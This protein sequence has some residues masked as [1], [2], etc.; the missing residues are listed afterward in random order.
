MSKKKDVEPPPAQTPEKKRNP[1]K[2]KI[3]QIEP[4]F[5]TKFELAQHLGCAV[6][7]IDGWVKEGTIPQP[8]SS[9]GKRHQVWLHKHYVV[10][11]DTVRW[12]KESWREYY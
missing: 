3:R 5:V 10:Y 11:R 2:H 4:D 12:P 1:R 6:G 7:T 8:H 9:P